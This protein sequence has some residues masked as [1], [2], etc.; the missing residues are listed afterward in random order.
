MWLK[1]PDTIDSIQLYKE[2]I[3]NNLSLVPGKVFF[4]NDNIDTNCLR[5]SFGATNSS[6][7]IKGINILDNILSK[8]LK[9]KN[10]DY[11]PFV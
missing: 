8:P 4:I 9:D 3:E 10:S 6:E 5:I 1:L 7:I 11:M 2:C